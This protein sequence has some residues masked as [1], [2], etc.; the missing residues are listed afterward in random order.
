M[1]VIGIC[2]RLNTGKDVAAKV[3]LT[4]HDF[5]K[6]TLASPIKHILSRYFSV[7][8]EELWGPSENRTGRTREMLQA[9]GT[10]FGRKYDP[11]VWV[12]CLKRQISEEEGVPRKVVS[13]VRFFN[14]AAMIVNELKGYIIKI[15]RQRDVLTPADLHSSEAAVDA[16]PEHLIYRVIQNNGT[17]TAFKEEVTEVVEEITRKEGEV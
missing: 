10:E 13:D 9:L 14:E 15:E 16:I 7:P 5:V 12:K 1:V 2:G 4:Q 17:L 11:D 6:Y 3:L 8:G